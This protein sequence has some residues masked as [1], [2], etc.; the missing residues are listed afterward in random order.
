MTVSEVVFLEEAVSDLEEGRQFYEDIE[1]GIGIYFIDSLLADAAS[2]QL[3]A[4]IHLIHCRYFRMLAKRFPFA[5]YYEVENG[6]ARVVAILDMRQ[7][8]LSIRKV[9]D[10]R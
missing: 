6:I 9:L 7:D 2:L 10:E 3:Y 5:V 1:E 4:G 8:P